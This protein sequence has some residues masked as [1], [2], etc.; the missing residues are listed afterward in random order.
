MGLGGNVFAADTSSFKA[1]DES[2]YEEVLAEINEEYGLELGVVPTGK[3]GSV[4]EYERVAREFAEQ[5]REL[6]DYIEAREAEEGVLE[7]EEDRTV[8]TR[9]TEGQSRFGILVNILR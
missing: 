9:A 4:S 6:L 2:V 1:V 5:Q 7:A 3:E 8:A